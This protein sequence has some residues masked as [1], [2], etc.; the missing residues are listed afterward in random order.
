VF[1]RSRRNYLQKMELFTE[2]PALTLVTPSEWLAQLVKKS[3]LREYPIA[4]I[5]NGIDLRVFKPTPSDF[6]QRYRLQDQFVIL[7]VASVWVE[8]RGYRY[9]VDLAEQLSPDEKIVLVGVS[10]HQV[11]RLPAGIIGIGRTRST[12]ELAEIYSAAD[13]YINPTLEDNFPTTNL[14][15]LACGTPVVTFNTGGSPECLDDE[16]GLVVER[17]DL[18]GL[19]TAIATVRRSRKESYSARC[20]KRAEDRFDKDA[21]FREYVELYEGSLK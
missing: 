13:V 16:S 14:E 11:K 5:N 7:A 19:V 21:R 15:A 4:L 20:R 10:E 17:G 6:R 18:A 8:H 9:L 12:T 1:D 2:V 3:F